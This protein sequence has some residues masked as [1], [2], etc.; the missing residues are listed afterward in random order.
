MRA[1]RVLEPLAAEQ[2]QL[3]LRERRVDVGERDAV[4]RHVPRRE[5]G[6][7]P[8]VG[9]RH[10]VE[11]LEVPPARVAAVEARVRRGRLGRVA[12]EPALDVVV[13]ELLAPQ[14]P[15]ERL[16]HHVRL[17]GR[18]TPAASAP[19]RTRRPRAAARRRPRRS[20]PT[21]DAALPPAAAAAR[22]STVAPAATSTRYRK[23]AFV[24]RRSGLTVSAPETTWSLIPSFGNGDAAGEPKSRS[25][26]VSLSQKSSSGALPSGP[27]SAT[28][29]SGPRNG[30]SVTTRAGPRP[31]ARASPRRPP[32]PRCCGTRRSAARAACRRP[33]PAFVIRTVSSR[34]CGSAFA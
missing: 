24:P 7:L 6:V 14:H 32:R 19:R 33:G 1:V 17:V 18:S 10:D 29:S 13:V 30:C 9:H 25:S 34:S 26:L 20:R 21:G 23:A 28:S 12:V 16:A 5:P 22:S 11:R 4:E 31:R 2:G 3:V 27:A 8:R 15:R